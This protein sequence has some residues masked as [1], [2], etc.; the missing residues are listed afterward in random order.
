MLPVIFLVFVASAVSLPIED[1]LMMNLGNTDTAIVES[2]IREVRAAPASEVKDLLQAG[3]NKYNPRILKKQVPPIINLI[4]RRN[5]LPV[6][7][8]SLSKVQKTLMH[9]QTK[10]SFFDNLPHSPSR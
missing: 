2:T 5:K 10:R 7:L 3:N 9:E 8:E 4:S 1:V 6:L